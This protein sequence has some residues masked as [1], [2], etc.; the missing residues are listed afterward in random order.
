M[1]VLITGGAGFIGSHLVR[2]A[3]VRGYDVRVL[4]DLSTGRKSNLASVE[5]D[6]DFVV[7]DIC[8]YD[9]VRNLMQGVEIVFHQAA[10]P[11]VPRSIADPLRSTIVNVVGTTTVLK[12]AVDAGVRR[13]IFAASS[14]AYGDVP[15]LLKTE[16]MLPRPLSPYAAT[17]LAGEH[18]L[19]AFANCYN[20]ETVG[21]RYFNVFGERQDPLSPYSGVIAKFIGLMLR[22]QRPVINGDGTISR[23]FT[24]VDNVVL[25]NFLAAE[26]GSDV[27]GRVLNVGCGGSIS[28]TQ[29]VNELNTILGTDLVPI[30]GPE[31]P[32]DVHHSCADIRLAQQVLGYEPVVPFAEGLRRTVEWYRKQFLG[33]N[34]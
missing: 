16:T 28:L 19:R 9:L 14:S 15:E 2:A 22:N 29:L 1:R 8:D 7:G 27:S 4:D 6:I 32:G 26:A 17:K 25:A 18:M 34:L 12:A 33:G 20:I 3:V 21:L 23:D 30:Y 11:S 10:L 13:V 5:Q 31:R 24:Y